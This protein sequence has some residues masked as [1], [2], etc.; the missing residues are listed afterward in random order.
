MKANPAMTSTAEQ[1]LEFLREHGGQSPELILLPPDNALADAII[2]CGATSGR[3]ARGLA[4]GV[5]RRCHELG[6][7][8]LG[9]EGYDAA[10][11]ILV[12][13]NEIIVHILQEQARNLYKL[14]DLWGRS[15]R[16]AQK[17]Q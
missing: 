2:I 13:C 11:W 7:N 4:D 15:A 3:Q 16:A 14:E 1:V 5:M 9:M 6:L 10:E 17:E 8:F 12:D